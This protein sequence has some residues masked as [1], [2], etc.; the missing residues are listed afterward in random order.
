MTA[1]E[2]YLILAFPVL[3][4]FSAIFSSSETAFFSLSPIDISELEEEN[5]ARGRKVRRLLETPDLLLSGILLGNLI[6]NICATAV[7]TILL[8]IYGTKLGLS[9][10]MVYLVDIA[11]MT[12][13]LLVL[14]EISPKVYAITNARKVSLEMAWFINLWLAAARPVVG[15][16]VKSSFLFKK[17]F[18]RGGE[19]RQIL[20]EELKMLVDISAERGNL[21]QEEKKLIHN[22]FELSETM[23]REIMVPRTDIY[24][25]P[26]DAPLEEVLKII[27]EKGHSR[28]PVYRQDLDNIVGVLYAKDILGYLFDLRKLDSLEELVREIYYVPET[29]RCGETLREFQK[30]GTY[31]GIVVDEYGGTEGLVTVEDIMEEIIGEIQDEHDTEEPLLVEESKGTYL[32]DGKMNI[33]DLSDRLGIGLVGEG[34][35][36]LGG[37]ILTMFD[38]LPHAGEYVDFEDLRFLIVKLSKRRITKV[39]ISRLPETQDKPVRQPDPES[40]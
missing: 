8:H 3:I 11:G 4:I 9:T 30:K 16:M 33:D 32:V 17:L 22:I 26:V 10:E 21:E 38:R 35:E 14:G 39:R 36:T 24:G 7:A 18:S 23:V 25:I 19:D 5:P 2:L 34:Y 31:M 15:L 29:K 6:V 27:R 40:I 1:M 20:E 28:F 12:I 13:L 37:F